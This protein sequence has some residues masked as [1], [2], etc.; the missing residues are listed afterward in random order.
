MPQVKYI[1][2]GLHLGDFIFKYI[3]LT[4]LSLDKRLKDHFRD[5]YRNRNPHK[6]NWLKKHKN[7]VQIEAIEDFIYTVEEAGNREI[8]YIEKYKGNKLLN[9][10]KGGSVIPIEKQFS[11]PRVEKIKKER[12]SISKRVY[13]Y[14]LDGNFINEY[15]SIR[16]ASRSTGCPKESISKCIRS[17]RNQS[18]G[19][20][21]KN[22]KKVKIDKCSPRQNQETYIKLKEIAGKRAKGIK[23]TINLT[24]E[25]LYFKNSKEAALLVN[26]NTIMKYCANNKK[27]E[28]YTYEYGKENKMDSH[29]L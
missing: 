24:K 17:L 10:T 18:K 14:D 20:M 22:Y 25:I 28:K 21:W 27:M 11:K 2:Y 29:P 1:I 5:I 13:Q 4:R 6:C 12:I 9:K 19:Y 7:N 8:Y 3:G 16:L 26:L 23:I 15:E